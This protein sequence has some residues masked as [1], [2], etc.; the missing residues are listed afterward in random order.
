MIRTF[1]RRM[2]PKLTSYKLIYIVVLATILMSSC[3]EHNPDETQGRT[4][5]G[6]LLREAAG[7]PDTVSEEIRTTAEYYNNIED[8]IFI[9]MRL[10]GFNYFP[11]RVDGDKR[12]DALGF[13]LPS[14]RYAEEFGFGIARGFITGFAVANDKEKEYLQAFN[15]KE[16]EAYM[17]ALNGEQALDPP[18]TEII[19]IGGCQGEARTTV[20]KPEWFKHANW[21]EA[22]F[23]EYY[24]RLM[25]DPRIIA[26]DQ[27]WTSCMQHAG[28]DVWGSD[29]DLRD[30]LIEE[31][32]ELSTNFRPTRPF[33]SGEEFLEALDEESAAEYAAFQAKEIELATAAHTC[34]MVNEKTVN[35]IMNELQAKILSTDAPD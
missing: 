15:H 29:D 10:E 23:N 21:L 25:A 1:A 27:E 4:L 8:A 13:D 20:E 28:H 34:S 26:I 12:V 22:S 19:E 9:C 6:A 30:S 16:R 11:R 2:H 17:I 14:A 31:F 35:S 7:L 3:S 33:N 32:G 18:G 5:P 24:D